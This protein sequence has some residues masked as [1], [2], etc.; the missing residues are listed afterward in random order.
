MK[1]T[2]ADSKLLKDSVSI[3][4]DLVTEMTEIKHPF[5]EGQTAQRSLDF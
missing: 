1:L 4:S 5:N 3:I 2:L